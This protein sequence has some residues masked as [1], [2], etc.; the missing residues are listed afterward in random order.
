MRQTLWSTVLPLLL[1][2]L[3]A[4]GVLGYRL[5]AIE[6]HLNRARAQIV[7][8]V[9]GAALKAQA[10][11]VAGIVQYQRDD[12]EWRARWAARDAD[13]IRQLRGFAPARDAQEEKDMPALLRDTLER[14]RKEVDEAGDVISLIVRDPGGKIL[15]RSPGWDAASPFLREGGEGRVFEVH[16]DADGMQAPGSG[17]WDGRTIEVHPDGTVTARSPIEEMR[18]GTRFGWLEVRGVPDAMH[19]PIRQAAGTLG[20]RGHAHL[21]VP[22][23][24]RAIAQAPVVDGGPAQTERTLQIRNDM[25]KLENEPERRHEGIMFSGDHV[26]GY[27]RLDEDSWKPGVAPWTVLLY[28]DT[29]EITFTVSSLRA[30]RDSLED[31]R[32]LLYGGLAAIAVISLILAHITRKTPGTRGQTPEND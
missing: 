1:T 21:W 23:A 18:T 11:S 22:E 14:L 20:D 27:A 13:L 26:L 17:G 31:W 25:Q 2:G 8:N 12:W 15:A 9:A 32:R 4:H 28:R 24:S 5:D 19:Q 30:I 3:V 10:S 29:G 7:T 6:E 16:P